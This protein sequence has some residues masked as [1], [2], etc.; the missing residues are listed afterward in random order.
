MEGWEEREGGDGETP[1]RLVANN[2]TIDQ[3]GDQLT[4]LLLLL[5]DA[6]AKPD[7]SRGR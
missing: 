3:S 6:A 7:G 5:A 4:E 2:L 1:P